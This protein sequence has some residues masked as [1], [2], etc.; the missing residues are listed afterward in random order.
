[1]TLRN[2]E[3][4]FRNQPFAAAHL[5]AD[6]WPQGFVRELTK[7]AIE[8]A[9]RLDP[10]G[11]IRWFQEVVDG[12]P[13]L[14]LFN[15]G[16]GM[17]A[18]EL[19]RL[20]D[21]SST[22]GEKRQGLEENYGHGG[23]VSALKASPGGVQYR[24]CK[25][26]RVSQVILCME[27]R[28]GQDYPVAVKKRQLAVGE[29]GA[30]SWETVLDVTDQY[31]GNSARPLDKDWTEVLLLGTSASHNTLLPGM[32]PGLTT[33]NWLIRCLNTRFYRFP[34]GVAVNGATVTTGQ[35]IHRS[36]KGLEEVALNYTR[37]REDIQAEH[38]VY[39]PVTVRYFLLD[40]DYGDADTAGSARAK[41]MEAYGVGTRGDHVC[42]VWKDECFDVRTGWTQIAGTFGILYGSANVAVHIVF[43]DHCGIKDT[44]YRDALIRRDTREQVRVEEF[45]ELSRAS[46]PDWL[47]EYIEAQHQLHTSNASVM[48]RLQRFLNELKAEPERRKVVQGEG[49]EEGNLR[50]D[51]PHDPNPDPPPP[52]P[53]RLRPEWPR[54]GKPV[55]ETRGI[56]EV[57]FTDE[58]ALLEEMRG[59]AAMYRRVDNKVFLTRKHFRYLDD[60]EKL[61]SEVG[62]DAAACAMAREQYEAA[63]CFHA[64]RFVVQAW[65]YKGKSDW[66]DSDWVE[67]LS[68]ETL[69]IHLTGPDA[70]HEAQGRV[71]Q[72]LGTGRR[73]GR[74]P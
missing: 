22:G 13:K 14:G 12:V 24:S 5:I 15:E 37:R 67:A 31:L 33:K 54:V 56:P 57:V 8:A 39:G 42:M 16:P 18:E 29:D 73:S 68:Q 63:Y 4:R 60:L 61:Y 34:P 30:E 32:V 59:R 46:R 50:L 69:T 70:L 10:P 25:A 21:L 36:A 72:R 55:G 26:A 38:P 2:D 27:S 48:D 6:C 1:M 19:V 53:P 52:R 64:G 62:S 71:R 17:S 43:P 40:G 20:T 74:L 9:M 3:V 65:L 58:P 44:T 11:D 41:S 7:N 23:K 51:E 28:P 47:V 45:A 66:S 35:Q 49:E